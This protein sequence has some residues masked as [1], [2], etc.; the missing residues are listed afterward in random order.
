MICQAAAAQAEEK[1][2]AAALAAAAAAAA[3]KADSPEPEIVPPKELYKAATVQGMLNAQKP[4][5]PQPPSPT[6]ARA[7][8]QARY[9]A[10]MEWCREAT[11]GY[12]GVSVDNWSRSWARRERAS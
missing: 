4:Q 9:A 6:R 3:A 11:R 5:R 10:I 8:S 12:A 1:A 7:T 2:V